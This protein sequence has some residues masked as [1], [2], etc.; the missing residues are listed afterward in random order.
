M[1]VSLSPVLLLLSNFFHFRILVFRLFFHFLQTPISNWKIAHENE[2]AKITF[3]HRMN[4]GEWHM[5][6]AFIMYILNNFKF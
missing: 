4:Y 5:F 6:S 3:A 1:I 2:V